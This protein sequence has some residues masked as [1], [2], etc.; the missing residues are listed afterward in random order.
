ME[1]I[2]PPNLF[3]AL[4]FNAALKDIP[5]EVR[6]E[7]H[8]ALV[9]LKQDATYER[10]ASLLADAYLAYPKNKTIETLYNR[11]YGAEQPP[12]IPN[13]DAE[14]IQLQQE[15]EQLLKANAAELNVLDEQIASLQEQL[16]RTEV[17]LV[18]KR[19]PAPQRSLPKFHARSAPLPPTLDTAIEK[20]QGT[21]PKTYSKEDLDTATKLAALDQ[22]IASVQVETQKKEPPLRKRKFAPQRSLPNSEARY[23]QLPIT[24][25]ILNENNLLR[26]YKGL[27]EEDLDAIIEKDEDGHFLLHNIALGQY[28]DVNDLKN[29]IRDVIALGVPVDVQDDEGNTPLHLAAQNNQLAIVEA[30][31]TAGANLAAKNDQGETPSQSAESCGALKTFTFLQEKNQRR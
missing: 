14:L 10:G 6:V 30:L 26:T 31:V 21:A 20:K 16:N 12:V 28:A 11:L 2:R 5:E 24:L 19:K 4:D 17:P 8:T 9:Y 25:N 23:A 18:R 13:P 22:K 3:L 27:V 7:V 29:L 1:A 15:Y